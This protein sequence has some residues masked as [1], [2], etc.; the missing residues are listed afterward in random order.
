MAVSLAEL[1]EYV[2]ADFDRLPLQEIAEFLRLAE[3]AKRLIDSMVSRAVPVFD[4]RGGW[5]HGTHTSM[6]TWLRIECGLTDSQARSIVR[7][8]R[9]LHDL[10]QTSAML[11]AGQISHGHA[12]AIATLTRDVPVEAVGEAEPELLTAAVQTDAATLRRHIGRYRH[13]LA[14]DAVVA[15]EQTARASRRMSFGQTFDGGWHGSIQTGPED[16]ELINTALQSLMRPAGPEDTRTPAQRRHDALADLAAAHLN[17]GEAPIAS[18]QRAH[19]TVI[20]DATSHDNALDGTPGSPP[21]EL[22]WG[23]T[24]S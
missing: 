20:V 4:A 18:G 23:G 22:Q 17:R 6:I 24:L 9:V 16:G 12:E 2:D 14:P 5:D 3:L 21:A 8:A 13:A 10:P 15:D 11:A 1:D 19:L 7:T